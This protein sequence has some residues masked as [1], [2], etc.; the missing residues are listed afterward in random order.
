MFTGAFTNV[1]SYT[2]NRWVKDAKSAAYLNV[3][4]VKKVTRDYTGKQSLGSCAIAL[5]K[6]TLLSYIRITLTFAAQ[7]DHQFVSIIGF[8]CRGMDVVNWHPEVCLLHLH[9]LQ[10]SIFRFLLHSRKLVLE[11]VLTFLYDAICL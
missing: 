11:N 6:R 8:E 7:D 1:A 9:L 10:V 3:V 2:H 5:C 4:P